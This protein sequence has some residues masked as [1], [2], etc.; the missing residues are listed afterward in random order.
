MKEE[1]M[2]DGLGLYVVRDGINPLKRTRTAQAKG[3]L[4]TTFE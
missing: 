2:D 3:M 1:F 4:L